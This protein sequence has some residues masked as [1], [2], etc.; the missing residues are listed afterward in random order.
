VGTQGWLDSPRAQSYGQGDSGGVGV[1]IVRI[2]VAREEGDYRVHLLSGAAGDVGAGDPAATIPGDLDTGDAPEIFEPPVDAAKIRAYVQDN[3]E[4]KEFGRIGDYLGKLLLPDPV[5]AGWDARRQASEEGLCTLLEIDPDLRFVPWELARRQGRRLFLDQKAAFARVGEFKEDSTDLIAPLRLLVVAGED[6]EPLGTATEM[7]GIRAAL[8]DFCGRIDAEFLTAPTR[9]DLID[10]LQRVRPHIFHFMGHG[11]HDSGEPA[12]TLSGWV[13][14]RQFVFDSFTPVPRL[15]VLNACRSGAAAPEGLSADE[16]GALS[17]AFLS[18]GAVAV[19]A[20]QGDVRGR[21]A[22]LFGAGLYRGLARGPVDQAVAAAR[23]AV[24]NADGNE[25]ARDWCLP[26][27]TLNVH[28]ERVLPLTFGI[29]D[30]ELAH[31]ERKLFLPIRLFVDRTQKRWELAGAVDPDAGSPEPVVLVTGELEAGK[32]WLVNWLRARCAL[33]GRRV[34]YVD[35][36]GPNNLNFVRTLAAI[37]DTPEDV[38]CL[39]APAIRAF[40]RFNYDLGFLMTGQKPPEPAA[41]LPTAPPPITEDAL[42]GGE[43]AEHIL[44][45]FRAALEAATETRPLTLIL[46]HVGGIL[47]ADFH[48]W[49]YPFLISEIAANRPPNVHLIIVLSKEESRDFWPSDAPPVN[50]VITLDLMETDEFPELAEEILLAYAKD[51]EA[52]DSVLIA[53]I[54]A[55]VKKPWSPKQLQ[56]VVSIAKMS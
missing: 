49:I 8:P 28:P 20:M 11:M 4:S 5:G 30:D 23:S 56:N 38:P 15:V 25:I 54:R 21:A 34:R 19:V 29:P 2:R 7:R 55:Y 48:T 39:A 40:D 3:P 37:R 13:L 42:P 10:A 53:S 1:E 44:A 46:D 50:S 41:E 6:S 43:S 31:V 22:G 52:D 32:T 26:A 36:K 17:D 47:K 18:Q 14:T 16:V 12:L 45:S 24:V 33:R 9:Q 51:V 35:F 27:L